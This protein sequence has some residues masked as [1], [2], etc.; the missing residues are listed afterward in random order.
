LCIDIS[1]ENLETNF[2]KIVEAIKAW[3]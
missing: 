3:S 2:Q 1:P